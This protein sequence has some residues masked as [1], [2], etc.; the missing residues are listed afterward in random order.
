MCI[1]II[2]IYIYKYLL[3]HTHIYIYIYIYIYYVSHIQYT[4][5][6]QSCAM[7]LR[8]RGLMDFLSNTAQQSALSGCPCRLLIVMGACVAHPADFDLQPTD[9]LP[10]DVS[11]LAAVMTRTMCVYLFKGPLWQTWLQPTWL[12]GVLCSPRMITK[13]LRGGTSLDEYCIRQEDTQR[14]GGRREVAVRSRALE[15]LLANVITKQ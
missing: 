7:R 11:I 9:S 15:V 10:I 13:T 8:R 14:R 12:N 6:L 2:H 4:R 3:R 5:P 1:M